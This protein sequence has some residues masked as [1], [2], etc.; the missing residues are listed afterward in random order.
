MTATVHVRSHPTIPVGLHVL[1]RNGDVVWSG[2]LGAPI[3]DVDF[4]VVLVSPV[5]YARLRVVSE[6]T[7]IGRIAHWRGK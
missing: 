2:P 7:G 1:Y 5:D 4:D 6:A 3:E